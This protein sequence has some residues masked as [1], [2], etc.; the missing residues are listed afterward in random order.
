MIVTPVL[1]A[2]LHGWTKAFIQIPVNFNE[3]YHTFTV[4]SIWI[5]LLDWSSK[6]FSNS[7]LYQH[8]LITSWGTAAISTQRCVSWI[9]TITF[10]SIISQKIL[11]PTIEL[12][13]PCL[14]YDIWIHCLRWAAKSQFSLTTKLKLFSEKIQWINKW[15]L[16]SMMLQTKD[17][18]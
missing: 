18:E 7:V 10:W 6:D 3:G 1:H 11:C 2:G 8:Q 5:N 9:S 12:A 4:L 15:T 14:I 16:T 17:P 13:C